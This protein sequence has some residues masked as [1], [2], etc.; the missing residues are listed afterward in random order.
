MRARG[1]PAGGLSGE[2]GFALQ[3]MRLHW[4]IVIL[5]CA[6]AG[7]GFLALYSAAG[8]NLDPWADRQAVRF[9]AGM[10]G[11]I[12]LALVDVRWWFR[13]A[14]PYYALCL[15][16]LVIVE[17]MGVVGMG[18]Q[19]WLNLGFIQIQPSELMKIGVVLALARYFSTATLEDTRRILFLIP[20][21]LIALVP[22]GLVLVQPDLGTAGTILMAGA[23]MFFLGGVPVWIFAAGFS[24]AAALVPIGWHFLHDYQKKRVT[25]FLD[26]ESDPLGAGYHITQSKIA[27]GSGG[28]E[29]R[30]FLQGTQSHLN[31]LPEKQT[32]FIFTLWAEE[33]GLTGGLFLLVLF[34]LLF[35]CGVHVALRCRHAFGRLLA[36]GLTVNFSLYVFINIAMVMGLIPVVGVPLPLVSYGGT[37]MLSILLSFG[38][39]MSCWLYGDSKM[40]RM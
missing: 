2:K 5:L 7:V 25:T 23:A 32:D 16:L 39:V 30:G 9:G 22:A 34:G 24:A 36:L 33:W 40:Q 37:A 4:G 12:A 8:G 19:R 28:V 29:G 15:T 11:M 3:L 35:A 20:A 27:L 1:Y 10:L 13:I 14:W 18:A 17:I 38:L 26:P 6:I 21:A 31:F